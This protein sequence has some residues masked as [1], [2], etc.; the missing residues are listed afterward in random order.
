MPFRRRNAFTL[1]ELLVVIGIIVILVSILLPVLKGI[2]EQGKSVSCSANM[3][4]LL[5]AM[6]AYVA[7]NDGALPLAPRVEDTY[8]PTKDPISQSLAYYTLGPAG[9][10]LGVID[11]RDGKLWRY[12]GN[13]NAQITGNPSAQDRN[14]GAPDYRE[15]VF[16][17]PSDTD[18]RSVE[19]KDALNVAASLRRNF[20]YSW[21]FNTRFQWNHGDRAPGVDHLAKIIEPA[22]KI[23][24]E[25]EESPND[26]VSHVGDPNDNGDDTPAFR[27]FKKGNYGFADGHV[28]GLGAT[29]VGYSVVLTPKT[30]SKSTDPKRNAFYFRLDS[31]SPN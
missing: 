15:R 8:P 11:Y 3:R 17:C 31:N 30:P 2:R 5:G 9:N 12:L 24:L 22:H 25:E 20:S 13:S 28:E 18:F 10:G 6:N 16:N 21:N 14:S 27:H 19:R 26:G 7:D 1:V 23:A 4:Q 29:D